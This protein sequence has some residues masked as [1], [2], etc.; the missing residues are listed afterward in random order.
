VK[1]LTGGVLTTDVVDVSALG[2]QADEVL[3]E[4]S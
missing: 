1:L 4:R 2:E 3:I